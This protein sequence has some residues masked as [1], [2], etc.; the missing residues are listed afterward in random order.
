MGARVPRR[1]IGALGLLLPAA[2]LAALLVGRP[3]AALVDPGSPGP[4]AVGVATMFTA[5]PGDN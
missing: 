4:Y 5:P 3:R 2:L 1:A